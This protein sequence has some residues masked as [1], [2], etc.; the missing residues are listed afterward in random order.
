MVIKVRDLKKLKVNELKS[1]I[2]K[3]KL[4]SISKKSK[5]EL[6]A[7][8]STAP[9]RKDLLDNIDLPVRPKRKFSQAQL[10]AQQRFKEA[11]TQ[12]K[13]DKSAVLSKKVVKPIP[14]SVSKPVSKPV[15]KK[16]GGLTVEEFSSQLISL[17][18]ELP[19][20][21]A[22]NVLDLKKKQ[23]NKLLVLTKG[24]KGGENL[25]NTVEAFLSS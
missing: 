2:K 10:D 8:I 12:R 20:F 14:K 15:V 3:N 7:L 4:G 24:M 18:S 11:A 5:T 6:M 1:I 17:V 19:E 21:I 16:Q 22:G 23:L 9:N 25:Q 13:K